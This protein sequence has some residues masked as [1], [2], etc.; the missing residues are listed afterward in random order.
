MGFL[1]KVMLSWEMLSD[2]VM[3]LST[4]LPGFERRTGG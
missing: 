2:N 3:I 1:K 4:S